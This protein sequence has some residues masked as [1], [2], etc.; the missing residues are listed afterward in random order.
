MDT[1]VDTTF[2]KKPELNYFY[3]EKHKNFTKDR[4]EKLMQRNLKK[5]PKMVNFVLQFILN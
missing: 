4:K 3:F 5:T 2:Q 1:R